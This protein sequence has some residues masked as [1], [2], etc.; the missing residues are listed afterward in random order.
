[1]NTRSIARRAARSTTR[2]Q[3][4]DSPWRI[5]GRAVSSALAILAVGA[6]LALVVVP[7]LLGGDSLTVLSGSM[8]PTFSPG[9]VVVVKGIDTA[10]VCEDLTV[11]SIVTFFPKPNDPTL[12]THRVVGK[13]IG[14]FDDGTE[15]RLITQ[16]DNNSSVD[17]PVSPAQVRGIFMFGVP[18]LG[19]ARQWVGENTAILLFIGAAGIIGWGLWSAFRPARTTVVTVPR[20][21]PKDQGPVSTDTQYGAF[22]SAGWPLNDDE[23]D[24]R[25]RELAVRERELEL[26]ERELAFAVQRSDLATGGAISYSAW[27]PPVIASETSVH[28]M[29]SDGGSL[30]PTTNRFEA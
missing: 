29:P 26:R 17:E 15:C 8:E 20:S 3:W 9:D 16:G 13:T 11:G 18:E 25:E 24:L 27:V 5:A 6:L 7:R 2:G 14:T 19:W 12:I 4:F 10:T 28:S 30:F 23:H 21:G 1:M 22:E